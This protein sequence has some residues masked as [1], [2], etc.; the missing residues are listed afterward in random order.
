MSATRLPL[1]RIAVDDHLA[2][3]LESRGCRTAADALQRSP[4]DLVELADVSL[5]RA[6]GFLLSVARAVA[7]TSVS[8][9]D[10][11]HRSRSVR[12]SIEA[13]DAALGGGLR[14]GAVTEVV[15]PAGAGK[16]QACLAACA[17][18]AA[19]LDAGGCGG[20]VI[21]VDAE[22]KFSGERLV[23]IARLKFPRAFGEEAATQALARRVQVIVPTSLSDLATRLEAMEE[24]IVDHG[25]RLIV[26]DSVAHLA[27]GEFGWERVVQR[28]SALGGV[29]STLKRHAE[30]HELAVLAVNQVTTRIGSA[31]KH[32]SD[33]AKAEE[34][35]IGEESSGITA[36]LGTKWAHCVNTRIALEVVDDRR[37]M[38][39]IKSPMAPLTAFEY[40][41][42][43]S[44]IKVIGSSDANA[45]AANVHATI[46]T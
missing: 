17:A 19:P 10:L 25:V 31:A 9:H 24:A 27:R 15:G 2:S 37:T 7:P 12:T 16:T 11:L 41:V 21:Y 40:I 22:R 42:D 32:A 20:G 4:L 6:R 5:E 43:A 45:S 36:A 38:K 28:Q 14:A 46:R 3:K 39:I 23:E 33:E 18:C 1:D 29:A 34:G 35:A 26:I 8:A 44:G 30:K 13:L